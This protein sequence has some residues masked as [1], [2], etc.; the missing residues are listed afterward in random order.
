MNRKHT[1]PSEKTILPANFMFNGFK[2]LKF[3]EIG[4]LKKLPGPCSGLIRD[5]SDL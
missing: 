4:V 2:L 5:F 3:K 1:I